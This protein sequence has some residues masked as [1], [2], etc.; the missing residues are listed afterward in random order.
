MKSIRALF[1][2]G[3]S[4]PRPAEGLCFLIAFQG[5]GALGLLGSVSRSFSTPGQPPPSFPTSGA[6]CPRLQ[7]H[8]DTLQLETWAFCKVSI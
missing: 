7:S 2:W 3:A 5:A 4:R 1:K 6:G 8:S